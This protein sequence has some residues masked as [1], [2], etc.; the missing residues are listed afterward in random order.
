MPRD[1]LS[2]F[3]NEKVAANSA[4]DT[5]M[6]IPEPKPFTKNPDS[7]SLDPGERAFAGM[8]AVSGSAIGRSTTWLGNMALRRAALAG[9][10]PISKFEQGSLPKDRWPKAKLM[11]LYDVS[12]RKPSMPEAAKKDL[13]AFQTET[14]ALAKANQAGDRK[15]TKEIADRIAKMEHHPVNVE[16]KKTRTEFRNMAKTVSSFMQEHTLAEKGVTVNLKQGPLNSIL[17]PRYETITKRVYLP[18]MNKEIALHE[19]GHAADYTAGR[20]GKIRR[21]AEPILSRGANFILPAAILAGDQ[22]AELL[23]GTVDDK[24]IKFVQDNAPAIMGAT[25]AATSLY[26]EAKA[27]ILA[28]SHINKIEGRSAAMKAMKRLGPVFGTYLLGA[29]PAVVGMSLAKKYMREARAEK[30]ETGD[31]ITK[32]MSELEK[33]ASMPGIVREIGDIAVDVARFSRSTGRDLAHVGK[34]IGD[35]TV[36]M[37]HAPGTMK[38]LTEAAKSVG[39]SPE[40]VQGAMAAALPSATT[41]LYLYGTRSGSEIRRRIDPSH[42]DKAYSNREKGVPYASSKTDE[43]WREEN[44]KLFAGLVGM[45]AAMSAGIMTKLFSDLARVL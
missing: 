1:P 29:I 11:G 2:F 14:V 13:K 22:I 31:L 20:I 23:P 18:V 15:A 3:M 7:Q 27:S 38:R 41:A 32:K 26:P 6:D 5:A 33:E 35:Q 37:V 10:V 8:M 43:R 36:K 34:Q 28:V 42:I 40:F 9:T 19:L 44:P 17:G 25:L 24:I 16:L 12:A 4:P 39:T 30:A 45:G 21:I